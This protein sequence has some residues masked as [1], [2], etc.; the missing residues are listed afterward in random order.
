M[1]AH[2]NRGALFRV[3][4]PSAHG[5]TVREVTGFAL[6]VGEHGRCGCGK[7]TGYVMPALAEAGFHLKSVNLQE[8]SYQVISGS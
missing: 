1:D 2:G 4:R 6:D 7:R 5:G 8:K 3:E